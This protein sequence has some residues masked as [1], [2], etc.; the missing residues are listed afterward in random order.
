VDRVDYTKGIIERFHGIE[1]FFEKYPH[2]CGRFSFVQIG[3]PSRTH[4]KSYHDLFAAVQA[5]AQR[6]NARF[7]NGRWKPI[8]FHNRHHAHEEIEPFYRSADLCLVTSL[9]DGMNLVA[10]EFV[11]ARTNENG[12]LILSQFT[13]ACRELR[14][15]LVVNPYDVEQVADSILRALQMPSEEQRARMRVMRGTIKEHNVYR[16]AA[17]LISE[18]AEIRL[19]TSELAET[20]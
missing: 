7:Q 1:R 14:D 6:I 8:V 16:W 4:I 13:G 17:D 10:K 12:V 5:E 3:A 15:A 20:R 9:H 11:A 18:V 2:Y 19:D